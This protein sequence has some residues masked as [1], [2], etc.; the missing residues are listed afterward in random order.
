MT[1][2]KEGSDGNEP[3]PLFLLAAAA[4]PV[5]AAGGWFIFGR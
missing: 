3:A 2:K 1:E 5:S 4:M